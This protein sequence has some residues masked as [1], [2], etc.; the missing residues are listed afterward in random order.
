MAFRIPNILLHNGSGQA[1]VQVGG[2]R[3][4]LGKYGSAASKEKYRRVVAET[5]AK[6]DTPVPPH[7]HLAFGGV[8][9]KE[10]ILA[11][12]RFAKGYY[13]K[14]GKLSGETDN[15][16]VAL[17]PVRRLYGSTPASD[18]GPDT[19]EVVQKKMLEDGLSRNGINGRVSRI[20]RMFRWASKKRL[21]PRET[22]YGLKS[23][24]GLQRGRFNV[25][26]TEPVKP[27]TV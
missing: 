14:N 25:R 9:V 27:V 13:R 8:S 2:H 22:Y 6:G 18:F 15:I 16:R 12:W 23:V 17:R 10:L 20:K 4:Y 1:L 3:I 11:Y 5:L 21:V 7:P 26:E 19:L 24:E